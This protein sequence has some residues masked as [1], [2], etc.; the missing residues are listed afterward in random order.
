VT[1]EA[2]GRRLRSVPGFV[3]PE[4][5]AEFPGLRLDW[6]T[7]ATSGRPRRSSPPGVVER[8]RH[9]AN[10]YRGA[11]VVTMRTRPIPHAYRAFYRQVGLDPDVD[12]IPAERV[13]VERLLHGGF[14]S[15]DL[16]SDACLLALLETGVPIW[17]VDA[18]AVDEHGLG[19]RT[20]TPVDAG[21]QPGSEY[22]EPGTLAVADGTTV[23]SLLFAEPANAAAVRSRTTQ[24]VLFSVAVGGVP[25]IHIEESLWICADLIGRGD[26]EE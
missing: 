3:S 8:L 15:V 13:A 11:T 1:G 25:A 16:T 7:V 26:S 23:H 9:L 14:A 24:V 22:L 2:T 6:M 17:A 20:T 21:W 12:R 5:A 10:R 18:D 19:I 4:V